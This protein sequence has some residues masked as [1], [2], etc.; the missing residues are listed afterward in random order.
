MDEERRQSLSRRMWLR[1]ALAAFLI[2][3]LGLTL[4]TS[5]HR[6]QKRAPTAQ[7]TQKLPA[8]TGAPATSGH[9]EAVG[10]VA[11]IPAKDNTLE[12]TKMAVSP[13][14]QGKGIGDLL[15]LAAI[16]RSRS[17]GASTIFLETHHRLAPAITLYHKHGFVDTPPDPNSAYSRADVRME[18]AIS[19]STR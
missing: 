9:G 17:I 3:G 16:E 11:L 2:A 12:L 6:L 4:N 18:L 5:A 19:W 14:H 7:G 8:P 1:F 15:M 10:T 13:R